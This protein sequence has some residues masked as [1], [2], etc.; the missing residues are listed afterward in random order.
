MK[1]VTALPDAITELVGDFPW[2][3]LIIPP[4]CLFAPFFLL[5]ELINAFDRYTSVVCCRL[6]D[7]DAH[8]EDKALLVELLK[9]TNAQPTRWQLSRLR[10]KI[11]DQILARETTQAISRV[12]AA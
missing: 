8:P 4:F 6:L 5:T 12:N 11:D 3:F 9:R 1:K 7:I 2:L 10:S